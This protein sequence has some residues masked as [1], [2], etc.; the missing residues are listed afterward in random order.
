MDCGVVFLGFMGVGDEIGL[1]GLLESG[2]G[3]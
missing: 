3:R 2:V 1:V